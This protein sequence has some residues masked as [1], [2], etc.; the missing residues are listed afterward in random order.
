MSQESPVSI[1]SNALERLGAKAISSF[2]EPSQW[3]GVAANLYPSQRAK[4][5]RAHSWNCATRREILAPEALAPAF[6]FTHQFLLP[7]DWLKTLQVG[8]RY[9]QIRY[10][11]EGRRLL[12]NATEL[13][14]AYVYLNDNEGTWDDL[15]V[16]AMQLQMAA[17]LAYPVTASTSLRESFAAEAADVVRRAKAI[18]GQDEPPE[19]LDGSPLLA[20]RFGGGG[21]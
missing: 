5:L 1:C 18:D 13:P 15:L 2:E 21:Y 11:Q 4:M 6:D 3:A 12:A 8:R 7:P 9:H 19:E 17:V 16:E 10:R 14:L 20:A